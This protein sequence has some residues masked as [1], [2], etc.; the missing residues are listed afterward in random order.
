MIEKDEYASSWSLLR[1]ANS[2]E[3]AF[4]ASPK[5][6]LLADYP[7]DPLVIGK[8]FSYRDWYK[9]VSRKWQPYVSEFFMRKA[10]PRR[11]LFNIAIPM[12]AH[13]GKVIGVLVMQPGED[14]IKNTFAD[15]GI[16]GAQIY[17][18]DK[19][20]N[21]VYHPKY[22]LDRIINCSH[23]LCVQR[24]LKGNKGVE[25]TL[26]PFSKEPVLASYGPVSECGWCIVINQ[27]RIRSICACKK[28][29]SMA[30]SL[31]VLYAS[32]WRLLRSQ[33]RGA[34]EFNR[35]TCGAAYER[36]SRTKGVIR[37]TSTLK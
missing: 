7:H 19:H 2:I 1:N 24:A 32:G 33:R 16:P 11:H 23:I 34:V 18:F 6:V 37:E 27:T 21:L 29:N 12:K 26:D 9:G 14:Y 22:V 30:C 8:D 5:G 15:I 4:I 3:R 35:G 13:D 17:I 28:D 25:K 36:G 31:Y 10:R 20:G